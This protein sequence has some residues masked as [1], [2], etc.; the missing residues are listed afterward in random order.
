ERAI[1]DLADPDEEVREEAVLTLSDSEDPDAVIHFVSALSD[2]SPGV[3]EAARAA[4][5]DMDAAIPA[6]YERTPSSRQGN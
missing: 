5:E 3:R 1:A 4:L 6:G 2:P